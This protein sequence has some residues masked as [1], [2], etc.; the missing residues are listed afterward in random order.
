MIV[1]RTLMHEEMSR[2]I[3]DENGNDIGKISISLD[4]VETFDDGVD[5]KGMPHYVANKL[6]RENEIYVIRVEGEPGKV[7]SEVMYTG[8][9]MTQIMDMFIRLQPDKR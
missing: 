3:R 4:Y 5:E 1:R 2:I 8:P 7:Q 6:G 9:A